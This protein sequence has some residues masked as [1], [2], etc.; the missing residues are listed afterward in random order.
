MKKQIK[1][2]LI[3]LFLSFIPL[4]INQSNAQTGW[5]NQYSGTY[6]DLWC[7][8][9]LNEYVGYAVGESGTIIK[10]I[11][12]GINWV[13]QLSGTNDTLF[14]VNFINENTGTVVGKNGAIIRTT[15]GGN[16]WFPQSSCT[17]NTLKS[18]HFINA[19]TG[20]LVGYGGKT[21][22]TTNGGVNWYC[23]CTG[24][25]ENLWSVFLLN[26][27]T[28]WTVGFSG[29]VLKT[30]NG[31]I[32]WFHQSV[33]NNTAEL[34]YVR[35]LNANTGI[36]TVGIPGEVD[37]YTTS[38][39]GNTWIPRDF[40]SPHSQRSVDFIDSD[41]W[42]MVGDEGDVFRTT[43]GGLT[44]NFLPTGIMNW[45][46]STSFINANTGWAVG[47]GGIILK[48]TS[49]AVNINPIGTE[50][51]KRFELYQNYPNPFNPE[52]N[53][54]FDIPK[55]SNVKIIIYDNLGRMIM[56][57]ID[58]NL[59]AGSYEVNWIAKNF[60]SGLYFYKI[61]A[62]DYINVKKMMLIK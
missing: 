2:L 21:M 8:T 37:I 50:I 36:I 20:I 47:T 27:N 1:R 13:P 30:T 28:G 31:G 42:M 33:N 53:I 61:E 52:T 51:P 14:C 62:G 9:F 55:V 24:I 35:F 57:L 40:W 3:A 10:T 48:T 46:F 19:N 5:S 56:K 39:G 43:D 59:S 58:K 45:L 25:G 7:V 23:Y 15:D 49:G 26:A 16:N 4:F 38:D 17:P 12:G 41:I 54:K 29:T 11:N 34:L 18:V 44:W 32:N 22:K 6:N 60:T